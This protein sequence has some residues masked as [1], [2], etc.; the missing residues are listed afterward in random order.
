MPTFV[1]KKFNVYQYYIVDLL[2]SNLYLQLFT[3]TR[4][5]IY[6]YFYL[7]TVVGKR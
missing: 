1:F 2:M 4:M 6:T 7:T 3:F 5:K